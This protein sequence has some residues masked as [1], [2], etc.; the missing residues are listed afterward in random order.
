[1][2]SPA[3]FDI[4][5]EALD[6]TFYRRVVFTGRNSQLVVM[7]IGPGEDIGAEKHRAVEQTLIVAY[8]FGVAVLN[9]VETPIGPG[10]AVV[11]VPGTKHNII[12]DEQGM[13]LYTIYAPPNHIPG[14]VHRTKADA[15][16]DV[17]DHIFG[18]EAGGG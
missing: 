9:G 1:M 10:D 16:A 2:T 18:R 14:T 17:E 15:E 5:G 8:G 4:L 7:A 12:A 11:V 6:N 3:I 13:K